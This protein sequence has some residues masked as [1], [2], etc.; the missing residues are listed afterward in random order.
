MHTMKAL[1]DVGATINSKDNNGVSTRLAADGRLWC[2]LS[3]EFTGL[4]GT[5][6]YLC[7]DWVKVSRGDYLLIIDLHDNS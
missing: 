7:F 3:F 2:S 4:L 5:Q 6:Y 1:V